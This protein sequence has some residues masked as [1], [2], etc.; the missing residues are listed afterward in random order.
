MTKG[1]KI[2]NII[3]ILKENIFSIITAIV[4]IIAI[5]QTS[6]QLKMSNKHF[7]LIKE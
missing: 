7:Y 4:A 1:G 6:K 2:V 5:F 3:D